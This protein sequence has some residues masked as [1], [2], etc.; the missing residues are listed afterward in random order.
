[1][2]KFFMVPDLVKHHLSMKYLKQGPNNELQYF[3]SGLVKDINYCKYCKSKEDIYTV[4]FFPKTHS[5]KL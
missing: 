5:L 4:S 3:E 1:M 2:Y